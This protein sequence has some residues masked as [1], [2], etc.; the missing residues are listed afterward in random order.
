M[1]MNTKFQERTAVLATL[2]PASVAASTVLTAYVP[3]ANFHGIAALIQTGVLGAAATVDAKLRQA[4]DSSGTGV[5]DITGK[6]L[7]QIVKASGDNKQAV[8]EC[9]PEELDTT[10]GFAYV[11][12]SVTVGTASSIVGAA[13]LGVNPRYLTAST[14]N[15]AGVA[16]LV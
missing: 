16:Q 3:V 7:T 6:A 13:L 14:F 10:N 8:I 4:T 2:D 1:T 12:L 5:K 9:R 11:C 15:Q